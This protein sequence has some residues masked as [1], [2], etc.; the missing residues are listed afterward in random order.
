VDK[1]RLLSILYEQ[2]EIERERLYKI[3]AKNGI[4]SRE[5]LAQSKFVDNIFNLINRLQETQEN[6]SIEH[7]G[8]HGLHTGKG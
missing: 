5:A 2:V 3:A 6:L 4:N 8:R 1:G 7:P